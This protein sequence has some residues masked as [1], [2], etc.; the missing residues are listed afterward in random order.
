MFRE[1]WCFAAKLLKSYALLP[2]AKGEILRHDPASDR[3]EI[4]LDLDKTTKKV[5]RENL[6][7]V[8]DF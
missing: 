3:Y 6:E 4:R 8:P 2:G 1:T 5:R 7:V